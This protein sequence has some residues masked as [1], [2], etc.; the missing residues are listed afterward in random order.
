M[1]DDDSVEAGTS[2]DPPALRGVL[3]RVVRRVL[4]T[5]VYH[6]VIKP[7]RHRTTRT[8]A[9]RFALVVRPT[10]FHPKWFLSS[11]VLAGEVARLDLRGRRVADV[12]TGSGIL[13]LAAARAG[14][15]FV[16]AIDVNLEAAR[17]AAENAAAN[18][19]A[20]RVAPLCG[21]LLSAVTPDA[22]FDLILSNP[23]FFSGEPRDVADRAWHA[24]PEYRDI[25]P[26]FGQIRDRL[27]PGGRAL[28]VLSSDADLATLHRL[29]DDAG[30][31]RRVLLE[32]ELLFESML[33]YELRPS[34]VTS[35]A[36]AAR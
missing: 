32:R 27:A 12:G 34:A 26:L 2:G 30:L 31:E 10:V 1:R 11:E 7:S 36:A 4:H 8:R 33:V 35:P 3:K 16:A 19:F 25:L 17:S 20:A 5:L 9:A 13:A 28:V 18:G 14:A 21:D 23:P 24:G 15:A 6:A 22:A 29:V